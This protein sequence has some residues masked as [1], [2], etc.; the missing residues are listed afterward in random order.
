LISCKGLSEEPTSSADLQP[1]NSEPEGQKRGPKFYAAMGSYAAIALLA[2]FTLSGNFRMVVWVFM[3][4][5]AVRTYLFTLR[6][7]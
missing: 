4:Y 5:L 3:G 1:D 7:P 2:E 6:T